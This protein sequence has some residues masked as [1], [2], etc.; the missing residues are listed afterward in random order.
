MA[1]ND[2]KLN[3]KFGGDEFQVEGALHIRRRLCDS[4]GARHGCVGAIHLI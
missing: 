4:R 2:A 3:G 1:V